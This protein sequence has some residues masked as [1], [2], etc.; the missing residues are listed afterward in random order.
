ML[1]SLEGDED[2]QVQSWEGD[3]MSATFVDFPTRTY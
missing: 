2:I 1:N 3:R